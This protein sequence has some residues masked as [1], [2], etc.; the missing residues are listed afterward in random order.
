MQFINIKNTYTFVRTNVKFPT[1]YSQINLFKY[2]S[3]ILSYITFKLFW[4]SH[5]S[6]V[7]FIFVWTRTPVRGQRNILRDI[8][9]VTQN[10]RSKTSIKSNKISLQRHS[11]YSENYANDFWKQMPYFSITTHKIFLKRIIWDAWIE[12]LFFF[13]RA[14][15]FATAVGI[16]AYEWN[17]EF[18]YQI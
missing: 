1:Q 5:S 14:F 18:S 9:I 15:A 10:F 6:S 17:Y 13:V 8:W 11:S 7:I 16:I 2:Y 4:G 3:S 12:C